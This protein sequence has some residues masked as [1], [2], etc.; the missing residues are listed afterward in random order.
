MEEKRDLLEREIPRLRRYAMV[1]TRN[2]DDAD[3]L[4][5]DCLLRALDNLDRWQSGT[6]MRAWLF[7]ILHRLFL[8]S[9]RRK[10]MVSVEDLPPA[11]AVQTSP[12]SQEDSVRL[13]EVA[14]AFATLSKD[15]REIILLVAVER[16]HYE[17]AA[18]I[19]QVAVGTVRSRLFRARE[20]LEKALSQ[21]DMSSAAAMAALSRSRDAHAQPVPRQ[22]NRQQRQRRH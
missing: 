14:K 1:L 10:Q 8:N 5:Q 2:A 11:Q 12:S 16:L 3:D 18:G 9:T 4:V 17:E 19:L 7:T 13:A 15:H 22:V 6:N 20:S 21:T